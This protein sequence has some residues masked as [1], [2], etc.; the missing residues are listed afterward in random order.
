[1]MTSRKFLA[2]S[3]VTLLLPLG[4]VHATNKSKA[5]VGSAGT[6]GTTAFDPPADVDPPSVC[7]RDLGTGTDPLGMWFT[8]LIHFLCKQGDADS[9]LAAYLITLPPFGTHAEADHGL[10]ARAYAVGKNN[11]KVL[12]VVAFDQDCRPIVE[13][14]PGYQRNLAAAQELT[15]IDLDNA[16]AWF[17]LAYA[18]SLNVVTP[19]KINLALERADKAPRIHDYGFDLLKLAAAAT[20][21]IPIPDA[22]LHI[23][24]V[25]PSSPESVRWTFLFTTT[26]MN[27]RL[28]DWIGNCEANYLEREQALKR[29]KLC[30]AAK[31][32]FKQGDSLLTLSEDSTV[33]AAIPAELR[34]RPSGIGN[35]HGISD[36]DYAKAAIAAIA[37]SNSEREMYA[38]LLARLGRK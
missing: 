26:Q 25:P 3:L 14:G 13:C 1:M 34:L 18:Q 37:E 6:N 32:Q 2:L 28:R 29:A 36:D 23:D 15:R 30:A 4:T 8:Q 9:L 10:L 11:P 22:A 20:G 7:E 33:S 21:Q 19:G 31:S 38:K 17:A 35:L 27:G 5:A 12:W 16:M 24:A